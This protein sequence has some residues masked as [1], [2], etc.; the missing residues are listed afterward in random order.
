ML[1]PDLSLHLSAMIG[2]IVGSLVI[3]III[4][5]SIM[6]HYHCPVTQALCGMHFRLLREIEQGFE[7][8]Y[9]TKNV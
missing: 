3:V 7:G 5:I 2:I 6:I 9:S 4:L 8:L 1:S